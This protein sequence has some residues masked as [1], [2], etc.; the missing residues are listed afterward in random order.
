MITD[1]VIGSE[2]K[3]SG[4]SQTLVIEET[5]TLATLRLIICSVK[6]M[7]Q[8]SDQLSLMAQALR[9]EEKESKGKEN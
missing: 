2:S 8:M 6:T 3:V 5:E 1:V 4:S 9:D 7:E